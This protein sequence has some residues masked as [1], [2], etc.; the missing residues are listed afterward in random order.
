MAIPELI[1]ALSGAPRP[2]GDI[3]RE[4]QLA[5]CDQMVRTLSLTASSATVAGSATIFGDALRGGTTLDYIDRIP[6]AVQDACERLQDVRPGDYEQ[7]RDLFM[8]YA[9]VTD[10]GAVSF[11]TERARGFVRYIKGQI[12]EHLFQNHVGSA[13]QL[14]DSVTQEGWDVAIR[15]SDGAYRYVQV[16]VYGK[17]SDVVKEMRDVQQKVLKGMINGRGGE[18]VRHVD[19]AVPENIHA[20]LQRLVSGDPE[21]AGMLYETPVPIDAD[22][23]AK[24]VHDGMTNVSQGQLSQFFHQLLGGAAVAGS[25]H[26]AINAFLWYK[27]SKEFSEAVADTVTD[28][29]VS[30]VGIAAC[31]VAEQLCRT[32]VVAGAVG[33]GVRMWLGQMTRSRWAFGDFLE[34]SLNETRAHIARLQQSA[35]PT[36]PS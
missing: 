33:I 34:H 9:T 32:V 17:A 20:D 35:G 14:A 21:L 19:F 25:L 11:D 36:C 15:Q 26:A 4:W 5:E 16:K 1:A 3:L 30:T 13:A 12:G 2:I 27:G 6:N 22:Q 8:K 18:T 31:L 29:A 24:L 23:A 7:L 28:T 10:N